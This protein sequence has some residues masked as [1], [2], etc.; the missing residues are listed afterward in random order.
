[1]W[2]RSVPGCL[3]FLDS[4]SLTC[5]KGA[6]VTHLDEGDEGQVVALST[7]TGRS[8]IRVMHQAGLGSWSL[9]FRLSS[10]AQCFSHAYTQYRYRN[11]MIEDTWHGRRPR[12]RNTKFIMKKK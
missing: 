2:V 5:E 12:E 1:M 9:E 3:L 10:G 8:C 7:V 4:F 6:H 11:D